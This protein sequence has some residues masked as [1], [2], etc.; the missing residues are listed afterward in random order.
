MTLLSVFGLL[1]LVA[2]AALWRSPTRRRQQCGGP[3]ANLGRRPLP[4]WM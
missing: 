1:L 3:N 2:A 4:P